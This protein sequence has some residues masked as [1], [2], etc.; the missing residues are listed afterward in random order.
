[1][2]HLNI[3]LGVQ[4]SIQFPISTTITT[5]TQLLKS[6]NQYYSMSPSK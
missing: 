3:L 4:E 2:Y 1:M 6:A 5:N